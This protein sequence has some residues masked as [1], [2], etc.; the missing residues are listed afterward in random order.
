MGLA[1]SKSIS[2]HILINL[3]LKESNLSMKIMMDVY[4]L[5]KNISI[6]QIRLY[7]ILTSQKR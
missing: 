7:Y 5:Q 6:D 3:S 1:L 2:K 4:L